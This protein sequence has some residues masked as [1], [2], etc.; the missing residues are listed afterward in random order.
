MSATLFHRDPSRVG[1]ESNLP[2]YAICLSFNSRERISACYIRNK[3]FL[4]LPSLS[5]DKFSVAFP[6]FAK[7]LLAPV[8]NLLILITRMDHCDGQQRLADLDCL[9]SNSLSYH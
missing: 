9:R 6:V 3:R 8:Q 7:R 4:T 5:L 1:C 2:S